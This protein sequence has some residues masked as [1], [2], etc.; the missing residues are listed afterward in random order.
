MKCATHGDTDT[1]LRCG[2]CEKPICPKCM[3][4]TPGGQRCRECARLRPPPSYDLRTVTK[5]RAGLVAA[6][7][8]VA[9]G[10][11]WSLVLH[12]GLLVLLLAAGLGYLMGEAIGRATNRKRGYVL[13]VIA[14]FGL[15]LA[16]FVRNLLAYGVP[17]LIPDIY[18]YLAVGIAILVAIGPLR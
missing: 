9:G 11:A 4:M 12:L 17:V 18:G 10:L 16:Y 2:R 14:G 15:L 6:G 8:G 3:I 13:Q 7:V 5:L 1:E